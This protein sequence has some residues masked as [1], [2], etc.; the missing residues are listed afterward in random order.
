[1]RMLE[2]GK[3]IATRTATEGL[4]RI[5]RTWDYRTS[6]VRGKQKKGKKLLYL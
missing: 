6:R 4:K 2:M 1:M 3:W 5:L